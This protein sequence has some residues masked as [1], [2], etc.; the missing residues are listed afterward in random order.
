MKLALPF[1]VLL[2][3]EGFIVDGALLLHET[4][5]EVK[6]EK[7]TI[8]LL[9][10]FFEKSYD[11][12]DKSLLEQVLIM[13]VFPVSL[14]K[15]EAP[16]RLGR[17]ACSTSTLTNLYR[18]V[19]RARGRPGAYTIEHQQVAVRRRRRYGTRTRTGLR[20]D[21]I[22]AGDARAARAASLAD[23]S[24]LVF[25]CTDIHVPQLYF[26]TYLDNLDL[27]FYFC[28]VGRSNQSG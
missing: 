13:K 12:I 24:L 27:C 28:F 25:N 8:V 17:H 3:W 4:L 7:T 23:L 21:P 18:S 19:R 11:K 6:M 9:K 16:L 26:C 10:L 1:N 22:A 2:L 15:L 20:H 5:Y 14:L